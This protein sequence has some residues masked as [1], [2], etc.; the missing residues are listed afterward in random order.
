V[1]VSIAPSKHAENGRKT[2]LTKRRNGNDRYRMKDAVTNHRHGRKRRRRRIKKKEREEG[3]GR[4][5]GGIGQKS[6]ASGID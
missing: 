1:T 4:E 5:E 6:Y 3:R 2:R